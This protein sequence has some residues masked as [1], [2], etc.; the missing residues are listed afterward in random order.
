MA[1]KTVI[2]RLKIKYIIILEFQNRQ[3]KTSI[4]YNR[5]Y[6]R[7]CSNTF[8]IV[9]NREST[10]CGDSST[11]MCRIYTKK[12]FLFM[13]T[14]SVSKL[15]LTRKLLSKHRLSYYYARKTPYFFVRLSFT[16]RAKRRPLQ[17][18]PAKTLSK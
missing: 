10:H 14:L 16:N 15:Y 11:G 13:L 6:F 17:I 5:T 18:C 8:I 4:S 1:R 12:T 3:N 2:C 9:Y 7:L